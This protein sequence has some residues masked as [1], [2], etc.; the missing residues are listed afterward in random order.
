MGRWPGSTTNPPSPDCL[1]VFRPQKEAIPRCPEDEA[2][3]LV[4][5]FSHSHPPNVRAGFDGS[6]QAE[7]KPSTSRLH[8]LYQASAWQMDL[9]QDTPKLESKDSPPQQ[10]SPQVSHMLGCAGS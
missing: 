3:A 9:N 6:Q 1:H 10:V 2:R 4:K 7:S 8:L 5:F